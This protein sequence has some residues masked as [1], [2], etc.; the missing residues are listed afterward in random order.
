MGRHQRR[1]RHGSRR[2]TAPAVK[3]GVVQ[4][5]NRHARTAQAPMIFRA[6]PE[7]GFRRVV[8]R[9]DVLRFIDLIPDWPELSI[10]LREIH[11][12]GG[13]LGWDG[14][15]EFSTE[16]PYSAILLAPWLSEA[17]DPDHV[18][19]A[20]Y[21]EGHAETLDRLGVERALRDDGDWHMTFTDDQIRAW[22]LLHIFLHELGHHV[23][24]MTTRRRREISRGE[25]FAERFAFE[26][27]RRMWPEYRRAFGL[28][29]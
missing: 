1:A 14:F 29:G 27:E 24:R 22:Q 12:V 2:K 21:V 18:W 28:R 11:L 4:R 9:T 6:R 25:D 5:K 8:T 3:N 26:R 19:A 17:D 23:D 20:D 13:E 15:Y 16:S 7:A 10:G